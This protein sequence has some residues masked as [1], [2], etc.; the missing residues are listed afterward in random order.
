[1]TRAGP[2]TR[3]KFAPSWLLPEAVIATSPRAAR[4]ISQ[5][6]RQLRRASSCPRRDALLARGEP[7]HD[8]TR[9]LGCPVG[10]RC[11]RSSP[12]KTFA[13]SEVRK[14][15]AAAC[16]RGRRPTRRSASSKGPPRRGWR[17]SRRQRHSETRKGGRNSSH[18]PRV[19]LLGAVRMATERRAVDPSL[20][21]SPSWRC[22]ARVPAREGRHRTPRTVGYR[23]CLRGSSALSC[24]RRWRSARCRHA[25][26]GSPLSTA[27]VHA[28]VQWASSRVRSG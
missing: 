4:D 2:V 16:P 18:L 12:N 9:S 7:F 8:Q 3:L 22:L 14:A 15:A 1:M 17:R 20:R 13:P 27:P 11:S 21:G 23:G 26:V 28:L 25:S 5:R 19:A 6:I 10:A 24:A